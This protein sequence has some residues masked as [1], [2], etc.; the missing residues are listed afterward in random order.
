MAANPID[1]I[2]SQILLDAKQALINLANFNTQVTDSVKR[3]EILKKI[4]TAVAAK[5]GGDLKKAEAAVRSF[6][7]SLTGIKPAEVAQAGKELKQ[8]GDRAEDGLGRAKFAVNA[9][10]IALGV[11]VS[12]LI[13][14][15]IQA[16]QSLVKGALD[17]L[18]ELEVATYNLIGAEQRLSEMGI[19]ISPK[20]LDETI[21]KLQELDPLLS[22]IQA[23]EL[24]SRI[25]ANVAPQVGFDA[26]QISELSEAVAILAIKNKALGYSFDE[27]EKSVTDAFLTGKVSQSINKFGVKINDQIVK[28]EALR[29]RLVETAEAFDSLT[30]KMEANIKAAAMLSILKRETDK[31]VV[32]LPEFLKTADA[33]FGQAQA[34]LS[35]LLT[36]IGS[37]F[38]PVL[39]EV[40]TAIAN[41]LGDI[42]A[43]LIENQG[44]VK[45][46]MAVTAGAIRAFA[47]L[48]DTSLK[49][50]I[51]SPVAVIEEMFAAF[52][53]GYD[54]AKE[55]TEDLATAA[56]TA[57]GAVEDLTGIDDDTTNK[58]L[59]ELDDKLR[60]I[61]IDAQQARE[62]LAVALSQK[63]EDLE[64]KFTEK[65]QD[66]D[67]EYQR[68]EIDAATDLQRKKSDIERDAER[69]RQR[70]LDNARDDERK[71]EEDHQLKLWELKMR[72]LMDLE[73]ALHAR[74]ARQI[75]RLQR[76]YELDKELLEKKKEQ[77][78]EERALSLEAD[79]ADVE[80]KRQERLQ[81][82]QIEYQQKLADLAVAK[83]RELEELNVW[84]AREQAD[85]ALWYQR[86]LEEID[87]Q[88]QQ[89]IERLLAG[90]IEEGKLHE[91]QQAAIHDIL[92]K[93]FGKNM[94]LVDAL[95]AY[96][97]A[98]FANMANMASVLPASMSGAPLPYW[99][100]AANQANSS[101]GGGGRRGHKEGG[102]VLATR[103]T[104]A[105]FGEGG[106]E[107]ATFT[108]LSRTG[109]DVNKL[110]G[111]VSG[112]GEGRISLDILLS[113]DLEARIV[114]NS[115]DGVAN[116]LARINRSKI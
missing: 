110:F 76:Q 106:P 26:K 69:D 96:T 103:P 3:V 55:G 54:D 67:T 75:I 46:F 77:E 60:D 4:I 98:A 1:I 33:A 35:D 92:V 9:L 109:R 29:M 42:N 24:V 108:P 39:F 16:F 18:R 59:Q 15:V 84:K 105:M 43:W 79:L 13:F 73:D 66:I 5:M 80:A 58:T 20:G 38:A 17:G 113:P 22:K 112:G 100:L 50:R 107:L 27:V 78:D 94:A 30:G 62:D 47:A 97:S 116:V 19:E 40:F 12:M 25:A 48:S 87:R 86:E 14:Q 49:E 45:E 52:K 63:Q 64:V 37:K 102:T 8:L 83:A 104:T 34:R 28:E 57:T 115:M 68:K 53:G 74:D 65:S 32:H 23:F 82:A 51:L 95:V 89:K 114:E 10:R 93:Y 90:Y 111:D 85:L 41:R 70:V 72:Y 6:A 91:E 2:A 101:S 56:D 81:D 71:A 7:N 44:N 31:E 36:T 99:E 11:L 88:T 61:A 21:K